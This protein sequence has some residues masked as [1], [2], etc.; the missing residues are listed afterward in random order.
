MGEK[1]QKDIKVAIRMRWQFYIDS[2][3]GNLLLI[4]ILSSLTCLQHLGG[5][6]MWFMDGNFAV[7]PT[8]VKQVIMK[9]SCVIPVN[10][11]STA[12]VMCFKCHLMAIHT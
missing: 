6:N 5:S 9:L 3:I 2:Y 12:A 11:T 1:V 7:V 10:N 4:S 8:L